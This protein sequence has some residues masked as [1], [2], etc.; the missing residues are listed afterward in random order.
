[1]IN[2]VIRLKIWNTL[3]FLDK[4]IKT[5]TLIRLV[6]PEL[7]DLFLRLLELGHELIGPNPRAVHF[8]LQ[9]DHL[10]QERKFKT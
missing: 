8:I 3:R 9:I 4:I 5:S 6:S 7:L 2:Q 1:M 10:K